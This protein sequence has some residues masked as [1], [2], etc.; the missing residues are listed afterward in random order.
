MSI[1]YKSSIL[2]SS[3]QRIHIGHFKVNVYSCALKHSNKYIY[4]CKHH[5]HQINGLQCCMFKLGILFLSLLKKPM[6]R[7]ACPTLLGLAQFIPPLFRPNQATC[8]PAYVQNLSH[9]HYLHSTSRCRRL[10]V[11]PSASSCRRRRSPAGIFSYGSL[12]GSPSSPTSA[13]DS[14]E[15]NFISFFPCTFTQ[16]QSSTLLTQIFGIYMFVRLIL[17]YLGFYTFILVQQCLCTCILV[18][19]ITLL[20]Y[21]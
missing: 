1:Y 2:T 18:L 15:V 3:T 10:L 6:N 14:S 11:E 16:T 20:L 13:L 19:R 8:G 5:I 4:I 12:A 9:P 21:C 7:N 17:E